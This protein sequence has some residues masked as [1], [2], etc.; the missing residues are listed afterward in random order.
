MSVRATD[1][2]EQIASRVYST[3]RAAT[4][5]QI[6]RGAWNRQEADQRLRPWT[7]IT[8]L[9][10]GAV[11]GVTDRLDELCPRIVHCKIA[12]VSPLLEITQRSALAQDFCPRGTWEPT[13]A[14]ARAEAS[15]RADA[16]RDHTDS[17]GL[18]TALS[19]WRDLDALARALNLPL[20][21]LCEADAAAFTERLAA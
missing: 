11:T 6:A 18:A 12:A 9:C 19:A 1:S 3:Y 13:L 14:R 7:A 4:L 10:G 20:R 5:R 8:L 15:A 17:E 2:L 16:M 21:M